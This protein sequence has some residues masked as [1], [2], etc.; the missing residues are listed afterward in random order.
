MP[1]SGT[2]IQSVERALKILDV[3][4]TG[5]EAGLPLHQISSEVGINPSTARHLLGTMVAAQVVE[6]DPST[7]HYRLG[8]HLIELG[9]SALSS[10]G[11]AR[12]ARP[13]LE[14]LWDQTGKNVTLLL[15]HGL[16]RTAIVNMATHETLSA[17]PAPI[18]INTMH[19]TGSGK[20]LLAYLPDQ[21]FAQ[22]MKQTR[23]DR[24]N[25]NTITDP[26]KLVEELRDIR[27]KGYAID[28][29]EHGIGIR[30]IATPVR[31]ASWRVVG[32]LDLVFPVFNVSEEQI[33]AWVAASSSIAQELTSQLK[34]I[35]LI[36]H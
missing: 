13:F 6:Q 26:Q 34:A 30:C 33:A 21:E 11:L 12:I 4:S 25:Q 5:H 15:F 10:T 14:K 35:G 2:R 24:F 29:E 8:I 3:L 20:L 7:K 23:L 27:Q 9:N 1:E 22:F 32:C 17:R 18:E 31:D 16:M 36:V 19:A 28:R